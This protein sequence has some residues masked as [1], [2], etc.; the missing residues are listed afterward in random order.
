M[1]P[2]PSPC[3]CPIP[4]EVT[5]CHRVPGWLITNH[6]PEKKVPRAAGWGRGLQGLRPSLGTWVLAP[7]PRATVCSQSFSHSAN[8]PE[9]PRAEPH[10]GLVP[11]NALP[12]HH[13]GRKKLRAAVSG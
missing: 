3:H 5:Q 11:A 1:L 4:Q 12:Q 2:P 10:T 7:L 9:R 8:L 13:R 6:A